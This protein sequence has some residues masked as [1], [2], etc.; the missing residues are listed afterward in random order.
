[1]RRALAEDLSRLCADAGV[2]QRALATASGVPQAHI[3]RTLRHETL[4]TV[5]TYARLAAAL[6][7]D[8]RARIYPNAGPALRDRHQA[9]ILEALLERLHPRWARH[10]EVAVTRPARG[11]VDL[12]L[13]E[14]RER[15]V[16]AVEIESD[17]R[18]IEQQVRWA[19]EKAG[20]LPSWTR[21]SELV[22]GPEGGAPEVSELLVV[23]RTRTTRAIARDFSMQ[24]AAAYPAHPDDAVAALTGLTRWP[25]PAL[26]WVTIDAR[27]VR[28]IPGR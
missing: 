19:H 20:S 27:G 24:L 13:H 16:V 28:F 21:W 4:P 26:A 9:R 7:G 25:G 8:L 6:G 18:R 22:G 23:R 1:M 14:A 12:V 11:W 10:T 3:S 15:I 2:S 17:I 5:E